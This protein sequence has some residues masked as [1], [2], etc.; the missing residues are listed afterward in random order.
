[1]NSTHTIA[2]WQERF[3]C[4]RLSGLAI[5]GSGRELHFAARWA[6][7]AVAWIV[8]LAPREFGLFSSR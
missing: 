1:M 2:R 5:N 4:D 7:L 3:R 8:T 6:A